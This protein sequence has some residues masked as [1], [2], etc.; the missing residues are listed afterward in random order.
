MKPLP[1]PALKTVPHQRTPQQTA[2]AL[3]RRYERAK[4]GLEGNWKIE[5]IRPH[6]WRVT[7][8][9]NTPGYIVIRVDDYISCDCPDFDKNELGACKHTLAVQMLEKG[10]TTL[11]LVPP[12]DPEA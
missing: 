12:E 4:A 2:Q 9:P 10:G 7:T 11:N 8:R 5:E 6:T 1:A 3:Q